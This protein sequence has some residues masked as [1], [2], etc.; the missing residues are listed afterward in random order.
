MKK[1]LYTLLF[2][3]ASAISL[4]SFALK[5]MASSLVLVLTVVPASVQAQ[6][7]AGVDAQWVA[8][9]GTVVSSA[10]IEF[11]QSRSLQWTQTKYPSLAGDYLEILRTPT[12]IQL[13]RQNPHEVIQLN[14]TTSKIRRTNAENV[15]WQDIGLIT[16]V[17]ATN[18]QTVR[19]FSVLLEGGRERRQIDLDQ[20]FT[21]GGA[22]S[23]WQRSIF[24]APPVAS[25]DRVPPTNGRNV[26]RVITTNEK[27]FVRLPDVMGLPV[28]GEF[29][30]PSGD[31]M[32]S[33]KGDITDPF[34]KPLFSFVERARDDWSVYL[35]AVDRDVEIQLDL[36]T[37]QVKY[38]T[39][40]A[41]A[42]TVLYS[43]A[44]EFFPSSGQFRRRNYDVR[45]DGDIFLWRGFDHILKLT[46]DGILF[47]INFLDGTCNV[48][49]RT[50]RCELLGGDYAPRTLTGNSVGSFQVGSMLTTQ[51]KPK[52]FANVDVNYPKVVYPRHMPVMKSRT[53]IDLA[54][55]RNDGSYVLSHRLDLKTRKLLPLVN[56]GSRE[57]VVDYL[58]EFQAYQFK[59]DFP[60]VT[61]SAGP[62]FQ[63]RNRTDWPVLISIDQVGCLYHQV[64]QP[65]K[66]WEISTGS[67]WF[68]VKASISPVL[69]EPD[70]WDC[71]TTPLVMVGTV[72][73]A[74]II[75]GLTAGAGAPLIAAAMM[76]SAVW[77][78]VTVGAVAGLEVGLQASGMS[79]R[80]A[81][82]VAAGVSI[83]ASVT[84]SGYTL[85]TVALP[86]ATKGAVSAAALETAKRLTVAKTVA[87]QAAKAT[88]KLVD[89]N[90]IEPATQAQLDTFNKQLTQEKRQYGVYAGHTWPYKEVERKKAV[91]DVIGGP[92]ITRYPDNG[93]GVITEYALE[94]TPF[95]L[96]KIQ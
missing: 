61:P 16:K 53:A 66:T 46:P 10:A 41:S 8:G 68:T 49:S 92:T 5:W 96:N 34:A 2:R 54:M 28:W 11:I 79:D 30:E 75:T 90:Q 22:A 26:N 58:R 44:P 84:K 83:F 63:I 7:R 40:K 59:S 69:A 3:L 64:I 45:S 18:T 56:N 42:K 25:G 36:Y 19:G 77:T 82:Y 4:N 62:G 86:K 17:A 52:S 51:D 21:D 23:G 20:I 91:F 94:T 29:S 78:G 76:Q 72:A 33:F 15:V 48:P 39:K 87:I 73:A 32:K 85:M 27:M 70:D 1:I 80:D 74:S 60:V 12:E 88:N 37:K 38:G 65:G 47:T 89:A 43:I 24:V 31:L 13:E 6:V 55:L 50:A 35:S 67:V 57:Q 95:S 14:F 81:A 9:Y 93:S 71:L